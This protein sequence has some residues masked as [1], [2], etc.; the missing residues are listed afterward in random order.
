MSCPILVPGS[1][2]WVLMS[3]R[4]WVVLY[5]RYQ[6]PTDF[7]KQSKALND[8]WISVPNNRLATEF[9]KSI[10]WDQVKPNQSAESPSLCEHG[11]T[12]K[13]RIFACVCD[14][15]ELRS[16]SQRCALCKMLLEALETVYCNPK[17]FPSR[18]ILRQ[19]GLSVGIE[20][21]PDLLSVYS[22][23]GMSTNSGFHIK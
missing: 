12:G 20:D 1:V 17:R 14:T 22:E 7:L 6:G 16:C 5:Q 9:I 8:P 11:H 15:S 4:L 2:P 19:N 18:V 3:S 21:G 23:P 10:G 13:A